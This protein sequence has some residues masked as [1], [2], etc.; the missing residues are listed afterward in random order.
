MPRTITRLLLP[1]LLI[2][3]LAGDARPE[4]SVTNLV[5]FATGGASVGAVNLDG[6]NDHLARGAD[7]TG[8]ADTGTATISFWFKRSATG[9]VYLMDDT[10]TTASVINFSGVKGTNYLRILLRTA[11]A[12]TVCIIEANTLFTSLTR[13][14]HVAAA[15]DGPNSRADIYVN[16]VDDKDAANTSTA[17]ASIDWTRADHF[18]GTQDGGGSKF[19]GDLAEFYV[20]TGYLDITQPANLAKLIQGG[21]PVE[22]G[23]NCSYPSGSV[24]ILCLRLKPGQSADN[25]RFNRGTG[26]DMTITGALSVSTSSPSD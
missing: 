22:L 15:C 7:Y 18:I 1:L 6:V 19:A 2:A 24:P 10:G 25:F 21:R 14:Y 12:A 17:N 13:W 5:G 8:S 4:L 3:G 11:A 23:E 16:G 20:S 26:G 9:A